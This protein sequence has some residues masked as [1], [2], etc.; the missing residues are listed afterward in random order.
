MKKKV[1]EQPEVKVVVMDGETILAGSNGVNS[2]QLNYEE[3][4]LDDDF[5]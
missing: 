4:S 3:E 2:Q 1:Y 5:E